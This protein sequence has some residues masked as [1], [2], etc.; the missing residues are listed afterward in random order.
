MGDQMKDYRGNEVGVGDTVKSIETGW[1]GIAVGLDEHN[2]DVMLRCKGVDFLSEA[3]LG[4]EVLC[5]DDIE[6]YAPCD[7]V[8]V[9]KA[10]PAGDIQAQEKG[11]RSTSFGAAL[12]VRFSTPDYRE[13]SWT[14]VWDAF[15]ARY[16][17]RW[18]AQ[19]FP[20]ADELVDE[21][22]IYHL[23]VFDEA[24]RGVTIKR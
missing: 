19:F 24:P 16:P 17:G 5:D 8:V 3:I 21:E 15:S 13:L 1:K 2:G 11:H 23:F 6:W 14:E 4:E 12:Y 9:R 18:A 10:K 7:V 22:N 20:P